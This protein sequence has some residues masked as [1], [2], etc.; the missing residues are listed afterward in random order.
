VRSI[1]NP[2]NLRHLGPLGD[3]NALMHGQ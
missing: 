1:V 2:D 3:V